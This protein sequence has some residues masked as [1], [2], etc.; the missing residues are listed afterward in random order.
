MNRYKDTVTFEQTPWCCRVGSFS[1]RVPSTYGLLLFPIVPQALDSLAFV[2]AEQRLSTKLKVIPFTDM[3]SFC[4]T[5]STN[6]QKSTTASRSALT[7]CGSPWLGYA[8]TSYDSRQD[9]QLTNARQPRFLD[10]FFQM[11]YR[12]FVCTV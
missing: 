8:S 10:M 9:T 3:H 5:L 2:V 11:S 12:V 1:L 6:G 4:W 7:C